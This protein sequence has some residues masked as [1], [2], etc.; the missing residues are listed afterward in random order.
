MQKVWLFVCVL[1]VLGS[2]GI[3]VKRTAATFFR[4]VDWVL[5]IVTLPRSSN[6]SLVSLVVV[7]G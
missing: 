1:A 2:Q 4:T 5:S 6:M 7:S 3:V